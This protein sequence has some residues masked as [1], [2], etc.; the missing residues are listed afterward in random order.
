MR[1]APARNSAS[2]LRRVSAMTFQ[3]RLSA[4]VR[5]LEEVLLGEHPRLF[6]TTY[7][8]DE[9]R[10]VS[11]IGRFWQ[12]AE[13]VRAGLVPPAPCGAPVTAALVWL[14]PPGEAASERTVSLEPSVQGSGHSVSMGVAQPHAPTGPSS[15]TWPPSATEVDFEQGEVPPRCLDHDCGRGR[16]A[17]AVTV[18]AGLDTE[19]DPQDGRIQPGSGRSRTAIGLDLLRQLHIV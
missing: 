8:S 17:G 12:R 9:S 19:Q 2:N 3:A 15:T 18:R 14:R 5:T 10:F 13:L 6:P 1:T 16:A 7:G 11:R 4:E